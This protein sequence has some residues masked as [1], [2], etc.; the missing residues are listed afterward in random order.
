VSVADHLRQI[1]G[2]E[3]EPLTKVPL[4]GASTA[5]HLAALHGEVVLDDSTEARATD[6]PNQTEDAA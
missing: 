3:A 4:S 1:Q 6:G 5:D 2:R